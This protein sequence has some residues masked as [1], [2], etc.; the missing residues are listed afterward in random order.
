MS[1]QVL[2][3]DLGSRSYPIVIGSGLFKNCFDLSA[4]LPGDRCLVVTNETVG[5]LYLEKLEACLAGSQVT[6]V[7]LPDGEAYKTVETTESVIDELV[8]IKAD[9]QT[10]VIALGGGVIGDIAGFA[11]ACYMRGVPFVQVPT[12]LLAQVDSS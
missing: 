10:S 6:S 3:V 8:A 12:T 4:Y 9:R 11:A 5:P 7:V 1:E 2:T